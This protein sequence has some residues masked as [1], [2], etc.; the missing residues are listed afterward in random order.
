ME[1]TERRLGPGRAGRYATNRV[2]YSEKRYTTL[3]PD[4]NRNIAFVLPSN[5]SRHLELVHSVTMRERDLQS[6]C[7]R[8]LLLTVCMVSLWGQLSSASSHRSHIVF[9]ISNTP[10]LQSPN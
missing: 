7:R 3:T 9:H 6:M 4:M 8:A 1:V 10:I 5:P 2:P